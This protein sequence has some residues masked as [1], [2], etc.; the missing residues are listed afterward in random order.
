M[1]R[2]IPKLVAELTADDNEALDHVH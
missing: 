2:N 1:L